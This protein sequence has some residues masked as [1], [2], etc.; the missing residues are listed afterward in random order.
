MLFVMIVFGVS[1]GMQPILGFN[2]G[3]GKWQRVKATL[4]AASG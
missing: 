4:R 1:Q 2:W 3:A